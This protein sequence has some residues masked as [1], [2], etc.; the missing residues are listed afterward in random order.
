[1][2]TDI[3][4][5][6][7]TASG[8]TQVSDYVVG[9]RAG[10][11]A[12][13][14]FPGTGF[15]DI[16]GNYLLKY[17]TAGANA[18]NYLALINSIS[19]LPVVLTAGGSD[20]DIGIT[21]LPKGSG[22]LKLNTLTW[23]SADGTS[24]QVI[25]T[26]GAGVLGWSNVPTFSGVSTDNAVAR[27]DG[28][29]G[30]IQNSGVVI[31]DS[32]NVSGF[33]SV[34]VNGSTSGTITLL[35][36]AISGSN[37]I[38][39]P[40]ATGTVALTSGIPSFPLS[41]ANGGTNAALVADNGAVVYSDGSALALLASTATAG[42]IL[43]SGSSA[44]PVWSTPT[45]P[46]ASATTR[47]MIVSDGTNWVASTETYAVPGTLANVMTSDGTNWTS[48]APAAAATTTITD[49]T[50]TNAVMY[51]V[52][53]TANTGSLALK[54]TST[55]LS[56]NPSAGLL[57]A[58]SY[59]GTWA[60]NVVGSTYGGTGVNNGASTITLG[61]NLTTSGAFAS[62]FTMTGATNVTFPTSGTLSTTTGTVT[63]VS[64]TANQLDSTGGAT[65]VL[66]LANPLIAPG[67][68]TVGNLL[69]SSNT[70]SSINAGGDIIL[71]PLTTG[72]VEIGANAT[73]ASRLRFREDTDNGTNY[74]TI[75]AASAL[76]GD[77]DYTLPDAYP[78]SN[79]YALVS[80]TGG[81]MSWADAGTGTVNS[82][83]INQIAYY[84]ATGAAVSGLTGGNGTVLV[85]NSTGVP[86]MLA[87]PAATGKVLQS[88]NADAPTWS[89]ATYPGTAGT[90]GNVLVSDGTNFISSPA[91]QEVT[92]FR[93]TFLLGG[94]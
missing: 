76:A 22:S 73:K 38:T 21:L 68:V 29:A 40:A 20:T 17:S 3:K 59:A 77:T 80:T 72:Q 7:F 25:S 62:T 75:G 51:P 33:A 61:G 85:T 86:S 16:N 47:K 34:V 36:T 93:E 13:F 82:G 43:Q 11:N 39:F 55:K 30:A 67:N 41:L 31:D 78:A 54:V 70:I 48:T 35:A 87:N 44:A 92:S 19:T 81:V 24:G 42:K 79:G 89:T 49:D 6:Q 90:A 63:S 88:V 14:D 18:V 27:F 26:D 10:E 28:I 65:P 32:N 53:V 60:G 46:S 94:M 37:T 9:L 23:V 74:I 56:F 71:S 64:G 8:D 12:K 66:S 15:K 50:T 1:M 4:F 5:S 69:I 91:S 45:Y 52:W 57:T 83:T 84:A 2:A 58:T